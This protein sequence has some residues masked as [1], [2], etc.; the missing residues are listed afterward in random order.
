MP[1]SGIFYSIGIDRGLPDPATK[2]PWPESSWRLIEESGILRTYRQACRSRKSG[3][4]TLLPPELIDYII[5]FL[6]A[7]K[8]SLVACSLVGRKWVASS[9]LH[10]FDSVY[11]RSTTVEQLLNLLA[12]PLC[13]ITTC[14][15]RVS[16]DNLELIPRLVLAIPGVRCLGICPSRPDSHRCLKSRHHAQ[17]FTELS[18]LIFMGTRFDTMNELLDLIC[19]IPRL[20]AL[21]ISNITFSSGGQALAPFFETGSHVPPTLRELW[22]TTEWTMRI[23]EWLQQHPHSYQ[24]LTKFTV[25]VDSSV[26]VHTMAEFLKTVGLS[27]EELH[28]FAHRERRLR[29]LHNDEHSSYRIFNFRT[30]CCDK[31]V[32]QYKAARALA[33]PSWD[34][35]TCVYYLHSCS[36]QCFLYPKYHY[37]TSTRSRFRHGADLRISAAHSRIGPYLAHSRDVK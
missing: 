8:A 33:L 23:L 11:I 25:G 29:L 21:T 1:E 20:E 24:N 2:M 16:L 17:K 5:D 9:R 34:N 27:L 12:S 28:I 30:F 10:L 3:P 32:T 22:L 31:P 36:N 18:H 13:T 4:H 6:H 37:R 35:I 14:I 26:D 7:H 15:R 19:A